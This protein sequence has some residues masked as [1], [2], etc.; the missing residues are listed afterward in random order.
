MSNNRVA[1]S[2]TAVARTTAARAAVGTRVV[3]L[4]ERATQG[5]GVIVAVRNEPWL[6]P[7]V[8]DLDS[9][10]RVFVS[11]AHAAREGDP[12]RTPLGPPLFDD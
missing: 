2:R 8:V 4:D 6:R 3:L 12:A 11:A 5:G 7:F 10:S 9:G 1:A